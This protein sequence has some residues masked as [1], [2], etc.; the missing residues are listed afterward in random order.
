ME[1]KNTVEQK[2][3]PRKRRNFQVKLI[4]Q[5]KTYSKI[6]LANAQIREELFKDMLTDRADD[7]AALPME[8]YYTHS[9][10][11]VID[12]FIEIVDFDN[13]DGDETTGAFGFVHCRLRK[14]TT[15]FPCLYI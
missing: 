6:G 2:T 5:D 10:H 13:R 15:L 7:L 8:I 3:T 4:F 14:Q 11:F 1:I 12:L 9:K